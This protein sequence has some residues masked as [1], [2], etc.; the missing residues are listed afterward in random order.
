MTSMFIRIYVLGRLET[1]TAFDADVSG[2]EITV[3]CTKVGQRDK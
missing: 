3:A 1:P 2:E